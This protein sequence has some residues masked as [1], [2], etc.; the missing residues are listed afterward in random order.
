MTVCS[1]RGL[2]LLSRALLGS[3]Q[4]VA[5]ED[6]GYLDAR[7]IFTRSEARVQAHPVDHQGV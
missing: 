6:P 7:H 3:E 1:Q 2:D 4:T 5:I